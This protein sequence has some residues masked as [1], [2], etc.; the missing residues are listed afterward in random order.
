MNTILIGASSSE[1]QA[2]FVKQYIRG[3]LATELHS[4]YV[5]FVAATTRV[6]PDLRKS[7]G[8]LF[9][10]ASMPTPKVAYTSFSLLS[11]W[12][13]DDL[14]PYDL[15][16]VCSPKLQTELATI[17]EQVQRRHSGALTVLKMEHGYDPLYLGIKDPEFQVR[18]G[19]RF[20]IPVNGSKQ[21][22]TI[23]DDLRY[24][25]HEGLGQFADLDEARTVLRVARYLGNTKVKKS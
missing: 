1:A 11:Q 4:V 12:R 21:Q 18:V 20:E 6:L 15:Y 7:Y 2:Q 19:D 14:K 24:S 10:A 22:I 23:M 5:L 8:P 9:E 13:M 17:L 16:V 25:H 3:L